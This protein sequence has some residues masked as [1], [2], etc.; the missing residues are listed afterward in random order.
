MRRDRSSRRVHALSSRRDETSEEHALE[1]T[2]GE[3][4]QFTVRTD[5]SKESDVQAMVEVT[6]RRHG[7]I[8][9]L[10]NNAGHSNGVQSILDF[11]ARAVPGEA[12]GGHTCGAASS[13]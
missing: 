12:D 9:C 3:A 1:R 7:H 2:H 10:V 11:D 6:L 4:V 13:A 8:D 5:V